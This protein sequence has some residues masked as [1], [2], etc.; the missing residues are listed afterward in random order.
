MLDSKPLRGSIRIPGDKSISHRA[1]MLGSLAEGTT[2]IH[3]F[4]QGLDCISTIN[5]FRQMGIDIDNDT[6][7][8]KVVIHG[9]GL[10]GLEKPTKI[11]DVGNS[12]TTIRL[13]AGILCGQTFDSVLTGDDSI[14]GRPMN[15]IITPLS[16]MNGIIKSKSNKELPPLEITSRGDKLLEGITYNSPVASAQVKS[17][18]LLA[19]LYANSQTKVVEPNLS[20][21]HTELMLKY[22]G[23]DLR[24]EDSTTTILPNPKLT[25]QEVHVPGDISSAAYFIAAGLIVPG[26]KLLIKDVGIN[27]TRDGIIEICK[28]MKANISLENIREWNGEQVADIYVE[29]SHLQG[30]DISG[31]VIPRLIDELP[32]IAIMACFAEGQTT[33]RD[34]QELKV[35]ETNRIDLMVNNLKIL[36]ADIK[37]TSDGMII[38]G[39][40]PLHGGI[41]ESKHDHRIAMSFAI[42]DLMTKGHVKI[43]GKE[44]V[45]ISYPSFFKDL[46]AVSK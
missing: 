45:N 29:H 8:N 33:I 22:F 35:K 28:K 31:G 3:N 42:V 14:K 34:A 46:E 27:P 9:K 18:I 44:C 15:R 20:R 23:A 24:Q 1:I 6:A 37:G 5:A 43:K 25:A 21:N 36:G 12:G 11:I 40:L 39:G 10:Y 16:K 17:S 13:L 26:S 32:I 7:N 2:T 19:G 30:V 41:V 38:E 4:L